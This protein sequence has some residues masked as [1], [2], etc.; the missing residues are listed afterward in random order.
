MTYTGNCEVTE[1]SSGEFQIKLLTSGTFRLNGAS[2]VDVFAVGGGGGGSSTSGGGGGYTTYKQAL[3]NLSNK[4]IA[5]TIGAGGAV[6]NNGA[7]TSVGD[8]FSVSGGTAATTAG[9]SG[10]N[11]GGGHG[12]THSEWGCTERWDQA[13]CVAWGNIYSYGDGGNGGSYGNSGTSGTLEATAGGSGQGTTTCEFNEGNLSGCTNGD[14]YAYSAGG[15]GCGDKANGTTGKGKS[16]DNSGRGGNCKVAGSSGVIILRSRNTKD[17]TAGSK[18]IGTYD[19]KFTVEG[20]E[21]NWV[22]RFL[23]DGTLKFK[24]NI[25]IDAFAVA[26]GG[27][28]SSTSGGGGGYTNYVAGA[29]ATA[30]TE[31][32]VVIGKGGDINTAGGDS[33]L[34]A[35]ITAKGGGAGSTTGGNGG[36]GGGGYGGTHSEWE[37]TVQWDQGCAV[38][39]DGHPY[40][41]YIYT[42]GKG[43]NGGSIGDNGTSGTLE[44]TAGGT[45]QGTTTCEFNEGTTSSCTNGQNYAYSSGGYGCGTGGNG[46]NGSGKSGSNSG[47]GGQCQSTGYSGIIA[48]RNKR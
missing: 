32:A 23:T 13:G 37:C 35:I 8:I 31:Y 3:S 21:N 40:Y 9:G 12:G 2:T 34:S 38:D 36:S 26:G 43:G 47:S 17:I 18:T 48:I 24:E 29:N 33:S 42:Y 1:T 5:I 39:A 25:D 11:G 22:V 14:N 7:A 41:G 16:G 6:D 19:G 30:G 10:G 20:D 15:Y 4:D 46:T 27:G 28:G 44:A 45:G